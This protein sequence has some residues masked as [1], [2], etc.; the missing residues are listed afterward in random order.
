MMKEG[1]VVTGK[2][3]LCAVQDKEKSIIAQKEY[4]EA[5]RSVL[6]S[7]SVKLSDERV[8][9]TSDPD[10]FGKVFA[11][12]DEEEQK[13]ARMEQ[14]FVLYKVKAI[15]A[16]KKVQT[17][18]H[19]VLLHE[20]YINYKSFKVIA[21]LMN[22]SYDYILELHGNALV[23]FEEMNPVLFGSIPC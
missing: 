2:E 18:K 23:E 10:K 14:D 13:L 17:E 22:Y 5:L 15:T 4:I 8:Q 19:R 12:I 21:R 3:Y 20:R 7:T 9:S 16:I 1:E 6:E 11:Q